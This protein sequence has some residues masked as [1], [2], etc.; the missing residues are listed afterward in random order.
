MG[1]TRESPS[2]TDAAELDELRRRAY[3]PD[4][5]IWDDAEAI[6]RLSELELLWGHGAV[7]KEPGTTEPPID[8]A[9]TPASAQSDF[10][11]LEDTK[12]IA[13]TPRR[14]RRM[15]MIATVG[16]VLAAVGS[17]LTAG[18]SD[19]TL[20]RQ[21]EI[22]R[23][24]AEQLSE[25]G[26]LGYLRIA[27]SDVR[28]YDDFRGLNVWSAPRGSSTI[29]LFVTSAIPP[30]WRVDCTPWGGE[31]TID[32]LQY[33]DDSRLAGLEAL[34]DVP[35]GHVLRFALRDGA[36]VVRIVEAPTTASIDG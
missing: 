11:A 7:P 3:G 4:A 30:R 33:R 21:L 29:C 28:L 14:R 2:R 27:R 18:S 13:T 1:A 24:A 17:T 15:A 8:A 5:D 22:P 25:V 19:V 26:Q 6:A 10:Q 23:A 32:L 20:Y 9:E 36:V 35:V 34:G 31:P 12:P 16:L